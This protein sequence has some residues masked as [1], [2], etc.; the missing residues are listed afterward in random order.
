MLYWCYICCGISE[1]YFGFFE[2]VPKVYVKVIEL[3][4]N[5]TQIVKFD[6]LQNDGYELRYT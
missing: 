1:K 3:I 4:S 2:N 6:H 5:P